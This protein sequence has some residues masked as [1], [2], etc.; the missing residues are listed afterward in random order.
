[1]ILSA[2][3]LELKC[4]QLEKA[5][6]F[7]AETFYKDSK[8]ESRKVIVA[9]NFNIPFIETFKRGDPDL[10]NTFIHMGYEWRV[11]YVGHTQQLFVEKIGEDKD[12]AKNIPLSYI[13]RVNSLEEEDGALSGLFRLFKWLY[14][15]WNPGGLYELEKYVM[16][17]V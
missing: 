13:T 10:K 3:E 6:V 7:V 12:I 1:M 4:E 2:Q 8:S 17:S 9:T 14:I 16:E 11:L 15:Y 5:A